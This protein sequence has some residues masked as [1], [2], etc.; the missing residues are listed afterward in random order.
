LD[1][2]VVRRA[3]GNVRHGHGDDGDPAHEGRNR[4]PA[5]RE[6][7]GKLAKARERKSQEATKAPL[8]LR[9]RNLVDQLEPVAEAP[10]RAEDQRLHGSDGEVELLGDLGVRPALDLPEQDDRALVRRQT[11]DGGGD[12]ADRRPFEIHEIG[13]GLGIERDLLGSQGLSLVPPL[14]DVSRDRHEPG[15]WLLR[16]LAPADRAE[17]VQER[18]LGDVLGLVRVTHVPE[19]C[20]VHIA[21]VPSIEPFERLIPRHQLSVRGAHGVYMPKLAPFLTRLEPASFAAGR[22][23]D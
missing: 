18:D 11:A 6:S 12:L 3:R 15:P 7:E 10:A 19:D 13:R 2:R 20:A 4:S 21:P 5:G 22:D 9:G 14:D 8:L 16:L 23:S 1:D 17:G